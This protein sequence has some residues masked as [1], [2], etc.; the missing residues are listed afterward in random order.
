[1]TQTPDSKPGSNAAEHRA[2]HVERIAER[3]LFGNRPVVLAILLIVTVILAW[4][5]SQLRPDASFEKM[6]PTSHPYIENYLENRADLAALGNSVR[7][8]VE[9][10]EG[11]IFTKEFQETLKQVT[12]EVFYVT[13]V[14]RAGLQS[15]WTPNVRW[16]EVTEEGFRG[17]AVIPQSYD[18]SPE[19]LAQLRANIERS[20]QVGRLVANN[21]RSA[22]VLAPLTSV[23]PETGEKLDYHRLSGDLETLIRDKYQSDT[24]KIHI[25]GFAKIVGDLIDG[26]QLV[27]MFFGIAFLITLVMLAYYSRCIFATLVP[28]VC[29][30]IAVIWQLGL[31]RA[32]GFG[33]D[34]YSML[35]PFLVF[36]IGMS[37]SIQ[38]I[39]NVGLRYYF[40]APAEHAA[41]N[42][43]RALFTPGM[44][45]LISDG[46]G[47]M[48]LMVIEIPVIQEL[49]LTA[50]IG[51]AVLILTNLVMLPIIL[52]Y[53]GLSDRCMKFLDTQRAKPSRIW[54]FFARFTEP[55]RAKG[56][57][58][59]AAVLFG[60]GLVFGSNL[61]IGDLDA[62]APELRADSR[63]NRDSAFLTANYSTGTDVF[64]VMAQTP[65][66][67]CTE[68][69][70]LSTIDRFQEVMSDVDGVQSVASLVD[71]SKLVIMAMN[72]GNPKW[73]TLSRNQ[74]VLNNS[75]S[76]VP[77]MLL[78]TDCSMV[79]V[80]VFLNDHKAETL[81]NVV[82]AAE[83]F[84]ATYN[85]E[86]VRFELAAGNSGVE[87]A[88]N[89][90]ISKAQYQM[91]ALVYAVVSFLVLLTFR[92]WRAVLCIIL[93][94]ALTSVLAQALMAFLGIG[95]KVA[96]LPVIA[97]GV[98]IGVDYGIY[99]YSKLQMQL[100]KGYGLKEAYYRTLQTTGLA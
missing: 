47:F 72:E 71:F 58:V 82:A 61:K 73:H 63:Y 3:L 40:G 15:I 57:I 31:L 85:N 37:H 83:E 41:R 74:Y 8:V 48:T 64:V 52:S 14:D 86:Q 78:N 79:P 75:L 39:N 27:G 35:V 16:S 24:I 68:Y 42:T 2:G 49:A 13:G 62:G 33:L 54:P 59:G 29:S 51:V 65:A 1:M 98:G 7:V 32:L 5:A 76:R 21:Y 90:V 93:P 88:T 96:T 6:I 77:S 19:T 70:T 55:K 95:V 89:I 56:L 4:Q 53:T 66:G 20:G 23:N 99:I 43:F 18:G 94:L 30:T 22:A 11:D 80:L 9:T 10:T 36:A 87:A 60:I 34:P 45:A 91:L 28:L 100:N 84:A 50:S 67:T 38:I 26:A 12:D 44:V 25:T 17:G 81:S 92:S 46:I 97:L 69:A